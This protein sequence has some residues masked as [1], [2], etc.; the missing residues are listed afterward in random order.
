MT[1]A[2]LTEQD[3]RDATVRDYTRAAQ[4]MGL[5]VDGEAIRRQAEAD[6]VLVDAYNRELRTAPPAPKTPRKPRAPRV[7]ELDQA[8][9]ALGPRRVE[10]GRAP[11][12]RDRALHQ[13][14][15][16]YAGTVWWWP[17]AVARIKRILQGAQGASLIVGVQAAAAPALALEFTRHW[18]AMIQRRPWMN[19]TGARP[20]DGLNDRDAERKFVTF[21]ESLCER[22]KGVLGVWRHT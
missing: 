20:Y 6:L 7:D 2:P 21:V 14:A 9:A 17:H 3:L 8:V 1:R 22:S 18:S 13:R 12:V 5:P 10:R 19:E 11:R 4:R 16:R 15:T